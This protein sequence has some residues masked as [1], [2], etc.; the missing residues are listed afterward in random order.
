MSV[1][2]DL[3]PSEEAQLSEAAR[4][5]GL[6]PAELVKDLVRRHLPAVRAAGGEVNLGALLRRWQ[7]QDD[8]SLMPDVPSQSLF[9]QWAEGDARMTDGEREAEDRLWADLEKVLAANRAALRLR[10]PG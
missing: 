1:I 3:T 8:V 5:N 2:V 10:Q 9:D 4:Q 7:E 6:T